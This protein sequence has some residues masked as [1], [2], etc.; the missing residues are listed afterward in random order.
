VT[1]AIP[2]LAFVTCQR[3]A[4]LLWARRNTV[5]LLARGAVEHGA[6]HYGVMIALHALW[7][8]G[9]WIL[10]WEGTPQP[11]WL[12]VFAGLQVLRVWVLATLGTRWTTRVIVSPGAALVTTGPYRFLAHP[13]YAI[14][15][16]EI[17]VLPI[18]F[19]LYHYAVL[20]SVLNAGVLAVR[21]RTENEAL[22]RTAGDERRRD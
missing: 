16:A 17:A 9:L 12:L 13:N 21:I 2:V 14:V 1:A 15:A 6:S 20:F 18:I 22:G 8:G 5:R 11:F 4:E 3:L 19:G 7:L 10:A